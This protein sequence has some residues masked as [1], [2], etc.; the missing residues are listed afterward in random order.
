[1]KK[2]KIIGVLLLALAIA[3]VIGIVIMNDV[4]WA[5]YNYVTLLITAVGGTILL[6]QK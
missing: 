4:Y 2:N 5:I 3:T 1:M 6:K